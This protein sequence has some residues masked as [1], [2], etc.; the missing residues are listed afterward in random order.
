MIQFLAQ[1]AFPHWN[2]RIVTER[3]VRAYCKKKGVQIV[4]GDV[5]VEGLYVIY[6]GVPFIVLHPAL[7]GAMRLWVLLHELAH[8]LSHVPGM[9]LFDKSYESKAD[10]QANF[11]A[12]VAMIPLPLMEKMTYGEIQEEYDYPTELMEIRRYIYAEFKI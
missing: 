2:T 6:G 8:H 1:K 3:E 4:E 12:A 10:F 11:I 9:Q 5:G 7:K